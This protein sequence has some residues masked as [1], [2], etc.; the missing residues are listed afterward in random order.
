M[1][2]REMIK[3]E[4]GV[5]MR[6]DKE[7]CIHTMYAHWFTMEVAQ[8]TFVD[9]WGRKSYMYRGTLYDYSGRFCGETESFHGREGFFELEKTFRTLIQLKKQYR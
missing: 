9:K 8:H 7:P 3:D 1:R 4:L 6:W 5:Y 2:K